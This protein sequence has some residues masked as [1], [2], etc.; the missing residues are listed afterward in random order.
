MTQTFGLHHFCFRTIEFKYSEP[1]EL[2][3]QS[4][5][6]DNKSKT[7]LE[8]A[9]PQAHYQ[10]DLMSTD[11]VCSGEVVA[12]YSKKITENF[13]P[14]SCVGCS[15]GNSYYKSSCNTCLD[16][17]A[18]LDTGLG[19]CV[20][21]SGKY[22]DNN[23]GLCQDCHSTCISCTGPQSQDCITCYTGEPKRGR[24]LRGRLL[25]SGKCYWG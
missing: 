23:T 1:L 3:T 10:M 12:N 14:K 19:V 21:P 18:T 9:T 7:T 13:C 11:S 15:G 17:I 20:C 25:T 16:S 4:K 6:I 22:L 5:L 2:I 8:A 24:C